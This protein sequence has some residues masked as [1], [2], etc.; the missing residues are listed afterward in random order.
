MD[1]QSLY[2]A[3]FA[4]RYAARYHERCA[5]L[6]RRFASVIT[7]AELIGG[8]AAF[9]AWLSHNPQIGA[10]TG[11]V[12]AVAAALNHTFKP[13]EKA[14]AEEQSRK[15]FM[16]L[17]ATAGSDLEDFNRRLSELCVEHGNGF[18]LLRNPAYNDVAREWG[19]DDS[20]AKLKLPE[21]LISLL[22]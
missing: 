20:T 1:Y 16:A 7:F 11:I 18:E 19:R 2:E 22:G 4:A 5:N 6:W 17:L 9:G 8:S 12:L 21:R 10:Y 15:A 3:R 14:A 13:S